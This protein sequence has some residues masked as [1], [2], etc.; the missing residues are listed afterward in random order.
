M[1]FRPV[2]RVEVIRLLLCAIGVAI[3][4]L[5]E[6][7]LLRL[8]NA[9]LIVDLLN[10]FGVENRIIDTYSFSVNGL[11]LIIATSCTSIAPFLG[12]LALFWHR[13]WTL[14]Q[15]IA[16]SSFY[17]MIFE[18]LN[19]LRIAF[20]LYFFDLGFSWNA[21]HNIPAGIFYFAL[22]RWALL[23]GGWINESYNFTL[24]K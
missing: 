14:W 15:G 22:L 23:T 18:I 8:I 17:F 1:K 9:Q 16:R 6:F 10:L 20:G 12:S 2:G 11:G 3:G 21:T 13:E 4:L 7:N 19:V 24:S 5:F